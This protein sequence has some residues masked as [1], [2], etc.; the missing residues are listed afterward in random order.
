MTVAEAT[1]GKRS[2]RRSN[3]CIMEAMA[4]TM[5]GHLPSLRLT[6]WQLS[7]S[8]GRTTWKQRV[9]MKIVLLLPALSPTDPS[10]H[11][12]CHTPP[13]MALRFLFFL[14]IKRL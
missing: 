12:T 5:A 13:H 11:C 10:A 3:G 4:F 7:A 6:G 2:T 14:R 1:P 9:P 8:G